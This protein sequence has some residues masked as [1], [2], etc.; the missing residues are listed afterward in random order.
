MAPETSVDV[1]LNI[2]FIAWSIGGSFPHKKLATAQVVDVCNKMHSAYIYRRTR[3]RG[4][5]KQ[6]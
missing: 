6:L 3:R 1:D 2:P 5:E 4:D